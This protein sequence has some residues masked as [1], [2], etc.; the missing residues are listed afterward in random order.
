MLYHL[1]SSTFL[2]FLSKITGI[3]NL[4][5]DSYFEGGGMHQIRRGG[6]LKIHA[7]FNRHPRYDLDRRLNALLYLNPDWQ[8]EYGGNLEL[9]DRHM[10]SCVVRIAPL[11]NRFVVFATTDFTYHGHPDPLTCPEDVTRKSLALYYYTH[12]RAT[13]GG[14][15]P[16]PFDFVPSAL[17]ERRS[18]GP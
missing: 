14:D 8:E 18:S 7:D 10:T 9:W 3:E 2:D 4:I 1:N 5:A 15:Q 17:R 6:K 12:E 16:P 13:Y 11:F